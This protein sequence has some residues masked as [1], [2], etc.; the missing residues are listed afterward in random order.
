MLLLGIDF[1]TTG[2][3][4]QTDRIIE[5]GAVVWSTDDKKPLLLQNDLLFDLDMPPVPEQITKLTGISQADL[6]MVG[7]APGDCFLHLL[8]IAALCQYV[9]AHNGTEF[10]KPILLAEL[11]RHS[12][13]ADEFN[14]IPW[15]DTKMDVEYP[16]EMKTSKLK[17]L[18]CEHGFVNPFA[19]RALF[20]V[21]TMLTIL[22]RYDI[23]N[24]I[25]LSKQPIVKL[26]ALCCVPW[27]DEGKSTAKAKELGFHW[28]GTTKQWLMNAKEAKANQLLQLEE[29]KIVKLE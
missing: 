10:D 29:L 21:L 1:E 24:V 14:S 12:I 27:N 23:N 15:I 28:N 7:K 18:A 20:D 11:K 19:H 25:A 26:Q 9:V 8:S 6:N 17:Y 13:L 3:N 22:S 2:L 16:E 5:I 4:T